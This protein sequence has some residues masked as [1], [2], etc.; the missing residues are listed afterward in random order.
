MG[1][2]RFRKL[3]EAKGKNPLLQFSLGQALLDEG[4]AEEAI[5]SLKECCE[6]NKDWLMPRLLMGKACLELGKPGEAKRWLEEAKRL[7]IE[8]E[9]EEP[10]EEA[11]LL[12]TDLAEV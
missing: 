11:V 7:S 1:S 8:Q 2:E 12:L 9:H 6:G 10:L 4:Q 5:A 3:L